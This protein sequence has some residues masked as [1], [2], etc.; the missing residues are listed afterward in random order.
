M[1]IG[2][3]NK[4]A[5]P[6]FSA[7]FKARPPEG[8]ETPKL[9][10]HAVLSLLSISLP[11]FSIFLPPLNRSSPFD[12][13]NHPHFHSPLLPTPDPF[14]KLLLSLPFYVPSPLSAIIASLYTCFDCVLS[15]PSSPSCSFSPSSLTDLMQDGGDCR[16]HRPSNAGEL[17]RVVPQLRGGGGG[18]GIE[19]AEGGVG[20]GGEAGEGVRGRDGR[21]KPEEEQRR[22]HLPDA[23]E[24]AYAVSTNGGI[25]GVRQGADSRRRVAA[26]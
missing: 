15:S 19:G 5:I 1:R 23:A 21:R 10:P 2:F 22:R 25:A 13:P 16:R 26:L 7:A 11:P 4:T 12:P 14:R 20:G 9:D 8:Y 3:S 24:A 17:R 18:G 6:G